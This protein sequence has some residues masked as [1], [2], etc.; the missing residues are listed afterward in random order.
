MSQ[1]TRSSNENLLRESP[2]YTPES[3]NSLGIL[4]FGF[5]AKTRQDAAEHLFQTRSKHLKL[6]NDVKTEDVWNRRPPDFRHIVYD[7]KPPKRNTVDSMRPW[8]YGTFPGQREVIKTKRNEPALF[9]I[10][11]QTSREPEMITR[12]HI[13]RPFTAKKKFVSQGVYKPGI[14]KNP[15]PHDF[16]QYPSLASLGLAEFATRFGSDPYNLQFLSQGLH[17][18]HGLQSEPPQRDLVKAR[19][20]APPMSAKKT[21][22]AHLILNKDAWPPRSAAFTRHRRRNRQAYSAFMEHVETDLTTKWAREQLEQ[23]I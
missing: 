1:S 18:V 12:F 10:L 13:D 6:Q 2:G 7:P 5:E 8:E 15:K 17:Q 11:T 19:Q 23:L 3:F 20:M 9:P 4:P 22:D 21:W 14:Y 16:R